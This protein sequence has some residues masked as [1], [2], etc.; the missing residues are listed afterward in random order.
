MTGWV[1]VA[2]NGM[3]VLSNQA[4][5]STPHGTANDAS[6]W[7][8][9]FGAD[10]EV[11]ATLAGI[12]LNGVLDYAIMGWRVQSTAAY[13]NMYE[14]EVDEE[15]G[16]GVKRVRCMKIVSGVYTQLGSTHTAF[17]ANDVFN[18]SAVGTTITLKQNGVTRVSVTDSA[19]AG[20]GYILIGSYKSTAGNVKWDNFSGGTISGGG[21]STAPVNLMRGHL[22][23]GLFT[24][25]F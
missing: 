11:E 14:M 2:G 4:T 17:A 6:A 5:C 7:A 3:E 9:A 13:D 24:G 1:D 12:P 20:G 8:T 22:V 16:V 21:G 15:G 23:N 19:I 10:Q 18:G 25:K